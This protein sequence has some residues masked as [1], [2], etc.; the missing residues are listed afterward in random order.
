M[1]SASCYVIYSDKIIRVD[2][3]RYKIK[4][5]FLSLNNQIFFCHSVRIG[6]KK[7]DYRVLT[8]W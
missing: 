5:L 8:R 6:S 1:K 7:P 4:N 3:I 2:I